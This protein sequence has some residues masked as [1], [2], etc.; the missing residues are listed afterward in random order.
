MPTSGASTPNRVEIRA[1]IAGIFVQDAETGDP[2]EAMRRIAM[3]CG[4]SDADMAKL[5]AS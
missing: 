3:D 4:V 5:D 1:S 2:T